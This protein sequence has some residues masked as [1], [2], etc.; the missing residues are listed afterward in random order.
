[1]YAS[2]VVDKTLLTRYSVKK[3]KL[4]YLKIILRTKSVILGVVGL[5]T[6][7]KLGRLLWEQAFSSYMQL[8]E[9]ASKNV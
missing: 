1:M 2:A 4:V 6:N 8:L 5:R 9:R 7:N 3:T